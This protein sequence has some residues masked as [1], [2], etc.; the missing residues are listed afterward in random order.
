MLLWEDEPRDVVD[1]DG[2][3]YDDGIDGDGMNDGERDDGDVL[4]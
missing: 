4:G 3:L 2:L 1:D